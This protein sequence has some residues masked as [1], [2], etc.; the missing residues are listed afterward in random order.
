MAAELAKRSASVPPAPP[1]ALAE[2]GMGDVLGWS[3]IK[4]YLIA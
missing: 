1:E 2:E 4:L 3:H